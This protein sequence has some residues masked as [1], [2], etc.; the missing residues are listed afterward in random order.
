MHNSAMA[1][2]IWIYQERNGEGKGYKF[3]FTDQRFE[4]GVPP[5]E[6]MSGRGCGEDDVGVGDRWEA[7]GDIIL[8]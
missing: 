5:R 2:M 6:Q 8:L 3:Y 7:Q 4:D 1:H